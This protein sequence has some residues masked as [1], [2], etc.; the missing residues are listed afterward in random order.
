[1]SRTIIALPWSECPVSDVM[2]CAQQAGV[3]YDLIIKMFWCKYKYEKMCESRLRE[4]CET[5][6]LSDPTVFNIFVTDIIGKIVD[7][8]AQK[9][10]M[11]V[12]REIKNNNFNKGAVRSSYG[13]LATI[14]NPECTYCKLL[15]DLITYDN[16]NTFID[17][18]SIFKKCNKSS[19]SA[20]SEEIREIENYKTRRVAQITEK[21][22]S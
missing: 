19:L 7:P 5:Y 8:D 4:E 12:L 22:N 18:L 17:F 13:Y 20:K 1:M 3:M 16:G 21:L 6:N 9:Y 15:R 2:P 10:V 11:S 14:F